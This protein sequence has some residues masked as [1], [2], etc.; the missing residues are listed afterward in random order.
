LGFVDSGRLKGYGVLRKC[1]DG[2]KIG[3]LFAERHQIAESLFDVLCYHAIGAPIVI[4]LPELNQAAAKFAAK[5]DTKPIFACQR[6]YLRGDPG[7]P[8]DNIFRITSFEAG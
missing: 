7:L 8:L 3:P 6:M 4:D 2:Y 1:R 5:H